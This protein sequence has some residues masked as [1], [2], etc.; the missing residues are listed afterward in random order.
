MEPGNAKERPVGE[1]CGAKNREGNPCK[2]AAGKNTDH[3]GFGYCANH[4]G[5]TP[6][7][8]KHAEKERAAWL[9]RLSNE[10]DPSVKFMADV[11]D[12]DSEKTRERLMA[13]GKLVDTGVKVSDEGG[14]AQTI[15]IIMDLR[16]LD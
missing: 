13:A 7:G 16:E 12:D 8:G 15:N 1:K 9:E 2:N 5:S 11:R 14:E 3:V 10:L 6:N 4:T